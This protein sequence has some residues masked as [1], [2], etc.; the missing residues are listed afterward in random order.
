MTAGHN[1]RLE[2]AETNTDIFIREVM[3]RDKALGPEQYR[4]PAAGGDGARQEPEVDV[5]GQITRA[6]KFAKALFLRRY[7]LP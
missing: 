7:P 1:C 4:R 6:N 3:Q 5:N 2:D